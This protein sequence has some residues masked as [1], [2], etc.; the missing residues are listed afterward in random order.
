M[1]LIN[2]LKNFFYW[3]NFYRLFDNWNEENKNIFFSLL[4]EESNLVN[5][6]SKKYPYPPIIK[7]LKNHNENLIK[8]L[9]TIK[10]L[11]LNCLDYMGDSPL[12][13]LAR[14][15]FS[16]KQKVNLLYAFVELGADVNYVNSFEWSIIAE[17]ARRDNNPEFF[18]AILELPEF[19]YKIQCNKIFLR[20]IKN[21][22]KYFNIL[23]SYKN[24]QKFLS[25]ID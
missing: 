12:I 3:D 23:A 14:N 19:N 18:K 9:L 1:K 11:D 10:N 13:Y 2:R 6:V 7:A 24:K 16:D 8:D 15:N 21:N 4:D 25:F 5:Y 17:V 20:Q 22:K